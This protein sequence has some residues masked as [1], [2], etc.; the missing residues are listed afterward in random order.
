MTD[1]TPT[2]ATGTGGS[3]AATP[4]PGSAHPTMSAA[5]MRAREAARHEWLRSIPADPNERQRI[6]DDLRP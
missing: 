5:V 4:A 2:G 6:A 3:V 1:R